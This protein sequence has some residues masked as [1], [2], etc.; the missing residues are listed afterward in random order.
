MGEKSVEK[1][2]TSVNKSIDNQ[3][4]EDN[5]NDMM[6]IKE[7]EAGDPVE[8]D[9]INEEITSGPTQNAEE[10]EEIDESSQN[11]VSTTKT[12][13]EADDESKIHSDEDHSN[14]M[15][16]IKEKEVGVSVEKD[17]ANEEV[18]SGQTKNA[19]KKGDTDE[20]NKKE[21]STTKIKV[22]A[23][24][25]SKIPSEEDDSNDIVSIK[26][27]VA[28]VSIEKDNVSKEIGSDQ[29][30]NVEKKGNANESNKKEMSTT[31]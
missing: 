22:E 25:E 1:N 27:K 17:D 12:K 20:S 16:S 4:K 19:E 5:S 6:G 2:K 7:K 28:G 3:T 31:K 15:V 21:M 26:E 18:G 13:V 10:K 11:E 30:Q 9:N 8:K 24:E 29:S 23:D 14:D